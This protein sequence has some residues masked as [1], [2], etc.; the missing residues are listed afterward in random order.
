[1]KKLFIMGLAAMGLALTACNSDETVEMAKGKAI[2]FSSFVDKSTRATDITLANLNSMYVYGWRGDDK[3]FNAQ[4]VTVAQN[5]EGTYSPLKYWEANY[6]YNFEAIAP[7]AGEKGVQFAAAKTGGTITFD[8]DAQTDLIYAKAT[9][10][11]MPANI[12]AA[13]DKV[14]FTFK[15]QLARV[16]FTFKNTFPA[17]AAAKI[18]VKDVKI[19][20][21][22]KKGTITPATDAK[23][24]ATENTLNVSF[25]NPTKNAPTDLV[26]N[27]GVGETDHMYLIPTDKKES[28]KVTFTVTLDQN[29]VKTDYNHTVTIETTQ[30]IGKSYNYVAEIGTSNINPDS[31]LHPIEFKATVD[32]WVDAPEQKFD[33]K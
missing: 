8:N 19:T 3:I 25:A 14:N 30:S 26:A 18:T 6:I 17:K 7:K 5:G 24:T 23:W 22:Y 27:T 32:T 33:L 21:A 9:E 1:M 11:T 31:Q 13:P 28:Y 15:H 2:G 4:E 16:K 12:T 10:T 29:G 20:N